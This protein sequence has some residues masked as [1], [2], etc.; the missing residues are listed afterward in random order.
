MCTCVYFL[1]VGRS[2]QLCWVRLISCWVLFIFTVQTGVIRTFSLN[3]VKN[4]FFD[5][6]V[7]GV[8]AASAALPLFH[9]L[10][11]QVPEEHAEDCVWGQTKEDRAYPLIQPQ[12]TLG[13]AHF[14]HTVQKSAVKASLNVTHSKS[15]KHARLFEI[16]RFKDLWFHSPCGTHPP[17]GCRDGCWWRQKASWW[18][19]QPLRWPWRLPERWA[20]CPDWA[21]ARKKK[22]SYFPCAARRSVTSHVPGNSTPSPWRRRRSPAA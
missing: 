13:L 16:T 1:R 8:L 4:K 10:S 12:Q 21:T 2:G 6:F 9:L 5:H 14:Q 18:W 22:H 17:A 7:G 3:L 15:A 20:S 11:H 19:P